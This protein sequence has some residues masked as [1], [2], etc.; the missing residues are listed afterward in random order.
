MSLF[1]VRTGAPRRIVEKL[2]G[3]MSQKTAGTL[4]VGQQVLH[5]ASQLRVAV[6]RLIKNGTAPRWIERQRGL[7]KFPH[8]L[9]LTSHKFPPH[10]AP[11][12][13]TWRKLSPLNDGTYT[14]KPRS[15]GSGTERIKWP[16][17]NIGRAKR[18]LRKKTTEA[19]SPATAGPTT[20]KIHTEL[21]PIAAL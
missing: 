8:R 2:K 19:F 11:T 5:H 16:H 14:G 21:I 9:S 15:P 10:K 17:M 1:G 12:R 18:C 6:A 7:E 20:A 4:I 3:G 13:K